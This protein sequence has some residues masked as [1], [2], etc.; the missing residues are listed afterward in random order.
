MLCTELLEVLW[1]GVWKRD[2]DKIQYD[3]C[4]G[5]VVYFEHNSVSLYLLV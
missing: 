2:Y 1:N 4:I 3:K 5:S